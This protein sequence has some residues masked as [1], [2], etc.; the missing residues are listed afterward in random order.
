MKTV[1]GVIF[2][3]F[4]VSDAKAQTL[5]IHDVGTRK[6]EHSDS[7]YMAKQMSLNFRELLPANWKI[8]ANESSSLAACDITLDID[9]VLKNPEGGNKTEYLDFHITVDASFV[10]HDSVLAQGANPECSWWE[11]DCDIPYWGGG[12]VE[13]YLWDN[14][15]DS[16]IAA[17]G[18]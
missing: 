13:R 1:I 16:R 10:H 4:L 14:Y 11:D 3:M 17:L 5:C 12:R 15:I 9:G 18:K 8:A 7:W 2:V 6:G